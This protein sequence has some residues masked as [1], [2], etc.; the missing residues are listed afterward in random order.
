MAVGRRDYDRYEIYRNSDGSIDQLPFVRISESPSDKY[1]SWESDRFRFDKLANTYYNNPFFDFLILYGNPEYI[2]E[3]DI[4]NG[5][6]IR[7][8]YPLDRAKGEYEN[9]LKRLREK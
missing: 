8:P 1:I 7:I 6:I 9:K 5:A 4:P 2:S 3:F